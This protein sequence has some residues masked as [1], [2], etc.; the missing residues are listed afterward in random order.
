[1]DKVKIT[2]ATEI[3]DIVNN[4]QL[5]NITIETGK[6]NVFMPQENKFIL[7]ENITTN[8]Q[9]LLQ[10]CNSIINVDLTNFKFDNV[11]TMQG[12]FAYCENLNNITFPKVVYCNKLTNM[13]T[14][15]RNTKIKHFDFTNW[16]FFQDLRLDSTFSNSDCE[17]IK[18]GNIN[19]SNML[20][21]FN[22]CTKLQKVNFGNTHFTISTYKDL[23]KTL[24]AF[25]Q[26]ES[27]KLINASNFTV[28]AETVPI[29]D[30]FTNNNVL[31]GC[32]ENC[33]IVLPNEY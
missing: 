17:T 15:F 4:L 22:F 7:T 32:N 33:V 28:E 20:F 1:M 27:L 6:E 12:W 30:V 21:T 3:K 10:L 31:L 23:S 26:C 16:I 24:C 2:K 14:T 25:K 8:V 13:V 19:M 18:F 11:K 29:E 5:K 9:N